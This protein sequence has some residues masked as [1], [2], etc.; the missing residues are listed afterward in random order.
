MARLYYPCVL[1]HHISLTK[2][3]L[4]A[5][6]EDERVLVVLLAH[7]ANEL[8]VLTKLFHFCSTHKIATP[9]EEQARNAQSL[10]LGRVLTG[11]IYECWELLRKAFFGAKLAKTY[12]P[13]FDA[14]AQAAMKALKQYFAADNLV[15][16]VRNR[17]AFHY[18]PDQVVAGYVSVQDNDPLDIYLSEANANTLYTF[19]DTIGGRA[20]LHD[21]DATDHKKAFETL[22][23]DTAK[24]IA[25]LNQV[26]AACLV[27][28]VRKYV[29]GADLEAI[30]ATTIDV[31][32]APNWQSVTIPYFVEIA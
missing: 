18:A 14:E 17:H 23:S 9:V 15:K 10:V 32:G 25:W 4:D 31:T 12:E 21:I 26:I 6:P 3:Q 13:S 7:A 19:A 24:V 8:N 16:T 22:V 5:I 29:G 30:G 28:A 1:L 11:K 27:I 2:A 20:M